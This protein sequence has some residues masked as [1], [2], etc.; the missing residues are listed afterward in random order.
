MCQ[1]RLMKL[2]QINKYKKCLLSEIVS[3]TLTFLLNSLHSGP[4]N[5]I[6][7]VMIDAP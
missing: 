1:P 5:L 4:K 2:E 7:L 6:Q 3:N